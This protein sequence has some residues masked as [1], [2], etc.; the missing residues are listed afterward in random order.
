MTEAAGGATIAWRF[1]DFPQDP[2]MTVT[3]DT[4][5]QYQGCYAPVAGYV[6]CAAIG[7]DL[8]QKRTAAMG[9]ALVFATPSGSCAINASWQ[10]VMQ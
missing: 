1:P 3:R 7:F 8:P 6:S 5:R 10:G 2:G 9:T 4:E